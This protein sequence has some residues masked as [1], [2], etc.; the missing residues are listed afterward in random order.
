M[1]RRPHEPDGHPRG[2]VGEGAI[3]ALA[4][5]QRQLV[6]IGQLAE[7]G[8]GPRGAQHRVAGGR[9]FRLH[10]GV[11]ALHGPPYSPQ[12]LYLAA[13]YACGSGSLVGGFCSAALFSLVEKT[14][15][16]PEIVA[17]T[18]AG[19]A[20]RGIHVRTAVVDPR[21]RAIR[22]GI[23]CTSPG[24]TII[25]CAH[26]AGADGTEEMIMAADSTGLLNRRRFEE[27][28]DQH[29][30]RPGIGHV[31]AIVSDDPV[32]LRN[33]N[34]VRMFRICRAAGVPLPLCNH[35]IEAE[36]RTFYADFCWP[37]L[38]LIVEAD[39]WRW[40]GG[41][42]ATERDRDRDQTLT[43]AGW[44][45]IHFTRDQIK[46][47]SQEVGRRIAALIARFAAA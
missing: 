10:S 38:G 42:R 3:A 21:D 12:Q 35:R 33:P 45:V 37:Q 5:R 18:G 43:I 36:G 32:E 2:R 34:E 29:R 31:L 39:S 13:H 17:P 40:H 47:Q 7:L 20:R 15:W 14:P 23:P 25:D 16:V 30:G 24:R 9:L 8:L 27:L 1:S 26:R 19:R 46:N 6:R 11:Y 44:H 22:H 4:S 41:R 28:A